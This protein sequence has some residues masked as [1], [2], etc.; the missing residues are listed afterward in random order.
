MTDEWTTLTD[1]QLA[2][3][4]HRDLQGQGAPVEA[5]RR[6]RI[7]IENLSVSS[8]NYARR[9]RR[10]TRRWTVAIVFLTLIQVIAAG[11]AI[12]AAF[13]IIKEWLYL[14][15]LAWPQAVAHFL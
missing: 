15:T 7:A 12:I 2:E 9:M 13:P 11:V 10:W 6:L 8:D 14:V 1:E 5:M 4:A 3:V